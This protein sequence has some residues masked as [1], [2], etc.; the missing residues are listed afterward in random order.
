M[1]VSSMRRQSA[2]EAYVRRYL[3]GAVGLDSFTLEYLHLMRP[4]IFRLSV[5]RDIEPAVAWLRWGG[6]ALGAHVGGEGVARAR[7]AVL[8]R[9]GCRRQRS[10]GG[11]AV[12]GGPATQRLAAAQPQSS[13]PAHPAACPAGAWAS[14]AASWWS[15]C[16]TRPRCSGGLVSA[17]Q[18]WAG[19]VAFGYVG[20]AGS[21]RWATPNPRCWPGARSPLCL[22]HTSTALASCSA[23]VD[24][25]LEPL[26]ALVQSAGGS[27]R[28]VLLA[29]PGIA[30]VPVPHL[31]GTRHV[32]RQLGVA[33]G[34]G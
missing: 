25:Q 20:A 2:N 21:R 7:A 9:T 27:P 8:A 13:H 17:T 34:A 14:A 15:W 18:P 5:A 19:S 22:T 4:A 29:Y 1:V 31:K 23:S 33:G 28:D 24:D 26:A 12:G 30:V 6:T 3:E 10:L 16:A 32:L 11:A